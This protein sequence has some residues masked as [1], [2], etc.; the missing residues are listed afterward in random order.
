MKVS[1]PTSVF[2]PRVVL[3]LPAPAEQVQKL[4]DL[5]VK[6]GMA[7]A[8]DFSKSTAARPST[9][10]NPVE[11]AAAYAHAAQAGAAAA[12]WCWGALFNVRVGN[13]PDV[14]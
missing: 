13:P 6:P 5:F 14:V 8:R 3:A 2:S 12:F 4:A 9:L 10:T 1:Q 7:A 11:F